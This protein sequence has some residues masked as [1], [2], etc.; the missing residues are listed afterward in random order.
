[1][2]LGFSLFCWCYIHPFTSSL[3]S[4]VSGFPL[5]LSLQRDVTVNCQH[6]SPLLGGYL[7]CY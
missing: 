4:K 5:V 7:C 3:G 1:M 6:L 2:L